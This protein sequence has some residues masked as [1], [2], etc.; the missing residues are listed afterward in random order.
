MRKGFTMIE[1]VFVIVIIGILTAV[2]MPKFLGT[3]EEAHNAVIKGYAGS[4]NRTVGPSLWSKS[5]TESKDG[6]IINYCSEL[7]IYINLPD[8]LIDDGSCGFTA[9]ESMGGTINITFEDGNANRSPKWTTVS[10][11]NS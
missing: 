4:L 2:A 6:L 9:K 10:T 5:F 7:S 1:L 8:E 3:A 11:N